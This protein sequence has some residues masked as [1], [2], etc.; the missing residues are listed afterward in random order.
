MRQSDTSQFEVCNDGLLSELPVKELCEW[1]R[2]YC[3]QTD[4]LAF[5][6]QFM[7]MRTYMSLK[8]DS[9]FELRRGLTRA[10]Y[11]VL[12][13][14]AQAKNERL[15]MTDIVQA[16]NVSP[17][18]ITKLVDLLVN[19]NYVRRVPDPQDKRKYWIEL[20]PSGSQIFEE[21]I[22]AVGDHVRLIWDGIT[23]QEKRLL[24]HLLVRVRQNI[25][26]SAAFMEQYRQL[27]TPP[28]I[29]TGKAA[30]EPV[31]SY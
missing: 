24:I 5:E 3:P 6:A 2:K 14:L 17:T 20:M 10:R 18:N 23:E 9:P 7:L 28:S 13:L 15:L 8:L 29:M 1:Y 31:G 19:D 25:L 16:M 4:Q 30:R 27:A 21:T 26:S 11:N 22:P 12:R